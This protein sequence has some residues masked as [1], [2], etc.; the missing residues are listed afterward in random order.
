VTID[1]WAAVM[2]ALPEGMTTLDEMFTASGRQPVVRVSSDDAEAFCTRLSQT[3]GRAYR[4][5]RS[6]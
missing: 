6:A 5:V 1:Q 3:A 2:G 4:P